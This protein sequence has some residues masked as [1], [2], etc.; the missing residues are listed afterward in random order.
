MNTSYSDFHATHPPIF[1]G[2]KDPL[3][4]EDRLRTTESKFSLLHFTEYQE[5]LYPTQQLRGPN[6]DSGGL[7][8][9]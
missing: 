1:S 4:A 8:F 9:Q 2:P 5:T 6:M 3:E 7:I